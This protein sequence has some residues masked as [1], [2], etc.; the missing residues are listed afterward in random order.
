MKDMKAVAEDVEST[1]FGGKNT[2]QAAEFG[3]VPN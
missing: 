3:D 1:C 2:T